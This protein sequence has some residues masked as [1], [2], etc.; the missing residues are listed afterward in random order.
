M[1]RPN[2]VEVPATVPGRER[3][4]IRIGDCLMVNHGN[5]A[6]PARQRRPPGRRIVGPAPRAV[7]GRERV[8]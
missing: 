5:L 4:G 6:K 8:G 2:Q 1:R 7:W 3:H